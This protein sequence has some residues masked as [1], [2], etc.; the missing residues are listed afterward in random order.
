MTEFGFDLDEET[1]ETFDAILLALSQDPELKE[2]FTKLKFIQK[3]KDSYDGSKGPIKQIIQKLS[4][5][6]QQNVALMNQHQ[7]AQL[8]M[9]RA[10]EDMTTATRQIRNA[11]LAQTA[12]EKLSAV[13]KLEGMEYRQAHYTWNE[14]TYGT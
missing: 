7:Q 10:V 6:E 13:Q 2:E 14:K 1:I 4:D 12:T 3:L 11:V 8:D 9:R 5:I